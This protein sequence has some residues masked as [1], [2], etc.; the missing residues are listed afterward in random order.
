M[1]K[2]QKDAFTL[3][4][5]LITLAVVGTL[6]ALVVPGLIKDINSKAMMALLQG[7]IS[8]LNDAVQTELVK[9][10]ATNLND[11]DIRNNP[12]KFLEKLDVVAASSDNK[13][14]ANFNNYKLLNG[15]ALTG[16]TKG[17]KASAK[18]KNGVTL[19]ISTFEPS[20]GNSNGRTAKASTIYVDLNGDNPP[21]ISGVD[22]WGVYIYPITVVDRDLPSHV[23]DVAGVS[24]TTPAGKSCKSNNEYSPIGC[25]SQAEQAG[26]DHNY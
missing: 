4:E 1:I 14:F 11:T 2:I 6:A 8:N 18:L 25:Y 3:S 16:I 19:C 20:M 9:T 22:L 12:Q 5:V 23:G 15:T 13:N 10:G 17:C 26:F 24:I 7:T 21:N